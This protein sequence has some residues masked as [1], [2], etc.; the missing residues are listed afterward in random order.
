[1]IDGEEDEDWA[2]ASDGVDDL[3]KQRK[4]WHERNV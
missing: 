1:M 2:Q 4:G 3:E